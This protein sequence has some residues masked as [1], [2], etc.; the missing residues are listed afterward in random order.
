[1]GSLLDGDLLNINTV[2]KVDANLRGPIA[3]A[4]AINAN[5][6]AAINA[7]V[8]ANVGS[9][10]SQTAA[11]TDQQAIIHQTMDNVLA[12]ERLPRAANISQ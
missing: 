9:V 3:G 8:S 11:V 4:A 7:L 1:M 2:V 10:G 6:A 5:A 12:Q